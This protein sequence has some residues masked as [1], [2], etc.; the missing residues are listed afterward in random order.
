MSFLDSFSPR[1]RL[2]K[3]F[4]NYLTSNHLLLDVRTPQE[5]E[6]GSIPEAVNIPFEVLYEHLPQL[7]KN[8]NFILFCRTGNRS[9]YAKDLL[10]QHGFKSVWDAGGMENLKELIS[11][12]KLLKK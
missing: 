3:R 2:V 7:N 12:N 8:Y 1:K 10:I 5:F 11:E 6:A 9:R 4:S